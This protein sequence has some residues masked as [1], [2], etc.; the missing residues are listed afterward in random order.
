[1]TNWSTLFLSKGTI[2]KVVKWFYGHIE[3]LRRL[4]AKVR[5][6]S[7]NI[8]Y[9]EVKEFPWKS[10]DSYPVSIQEAFCKFYE[11]TIIISFDRCR[12]NPE[13]TFLHI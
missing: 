1:M 13:K 6:D 11:Y 12:G 10:L 7:E 2:K 3:C 4:I 8:P 9:P 5:R